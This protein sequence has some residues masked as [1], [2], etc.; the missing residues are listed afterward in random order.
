MLGWTPRPPI[1]DAD[2]ADEE[3][4]KTLPQGRFPRAVP[5]QPEQHGDHSSTATQLSVLA[6]ALVGLV[7]QCGYRCDTYALGHS[8]HAV[9]MSGQWECV[10]GT[11]LGLCCYQRPI[12]TH[13]T[14]LLALPHTA[15][16]IATAAIPSSAAHPVIEQQ[17]ALILVDRCADLATPLLLHDA[18]LPAAA[19]VLPRRPAG[20]A[21][22]PAHA[23]DGVWQTADVAVDMRDVL[24]P[25]EP[26]NDAGEPHT[27]A[28][29][30]RQ[31]LP[32]QRPI[33]RRVVDPSQPQSGQWWEFLVGRQG[34]DGVLFVRKW[35][36]EALRQVVHDVSIV[37][38]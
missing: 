6:H 27:D 19:Q 20:V 1:V 4:Q 7:A 35:V 13:V 36:K 17:A 18:F 9:G 25:R 21:T 5:Q 23:V 24:Q 32:S 14:H 31:P 8:A 16:E 15:Q 26:D 33:L 38:A 34:K 37:C 3:Q 2:D 29:P 30:A 22:S 10:A 12:A 11:H 28:A